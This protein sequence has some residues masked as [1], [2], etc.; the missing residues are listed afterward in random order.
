MN[1]IK[2]VENALIRC[3]P[4]CDVKDFIKICEGCFKDIASL[5]LDDRSEFERQLGP[6]VH[7]CVDLMLLV[8]HEKKLISVADEVIVAL[9]DQRN[10]FLQKRPAKFAYCV[11]AEKTIPL[12]ENDNKKLEVISNHATKILEL[13][14]NS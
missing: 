10:K 5:N 3:S 2:E 4:D 9:W 11:V 8:N 1:K 7:D 14:K 6:R 12:L 13:C